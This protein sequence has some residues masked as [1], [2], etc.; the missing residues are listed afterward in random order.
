MS[1]QLWET[2]MNPETRRLIQIT[3]DDAEMAEEIITACM[4]EDSSARREFVL[5]PERFE[6]DNDN[7]GVDVVA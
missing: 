5:Y 1:E 6:N 4:D 2:T 7:D 3:M